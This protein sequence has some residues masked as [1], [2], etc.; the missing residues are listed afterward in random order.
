MPDKDKKRLETVKTPPELQSS[1]PP[2]PEEL[3]AMIQADRQT[4]ELRATERIKAVLAE[5]RCSMN[6]TMSLTVRGI[7]PGIEITAQD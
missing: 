7:I 3:K 5:E 6:P 4:R 2:L 1:A